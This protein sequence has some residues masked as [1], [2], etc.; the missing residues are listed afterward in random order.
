VPVDSAVGLVETTGLTAA[1]RAADAMTKAA[2]VALLGRVR[3]GAGLVTVVV[4]GDIASVQVAVE[5]GCEATGARAV[6][7]V[8]GRPA[9]GVLELLARGL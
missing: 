7:H 4:V 9:P 5:A 2:E 8:I 3:I 1:I 6:G